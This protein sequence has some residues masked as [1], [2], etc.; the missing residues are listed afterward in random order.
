[1]KSLLLIL[2][3][4]LEDYAW[5]LL[6]ALDQLLN[7]FLFGHP[8]ETFS[9]RTQR[10]AEAGQWFWRLSRWLINKIFFWQEDHCRASF[11][12]EAERKHSPREYA[13]G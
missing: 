2:M 13:D 7:T 4:W 12:S 9:A 10:K 8:D 3:T 11:E 5:N 6:V 1:M